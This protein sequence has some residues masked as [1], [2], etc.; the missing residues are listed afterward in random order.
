[1]TNNLSYYP[2]LFLRHFTEKCTDSI[3]LVIGGSAA[4]LHLEKLISKDIQIPLVDI[5][6]EIISSKS[7]EII[8]SFLV[9][10]AEEFCEKYGLT[11]TINKKSNHIDYINLYLD[12]VKQIPLNYFI[13]QHY[14]NEINKCDIINIDGLNVKTFDHIFIETENHICHLTDDIE[15]LKKNYNDSYKKELEAVTNKLERK[16]T[17]MKLF[18]SMTKKIENLSFSN[19]N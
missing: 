16:N 3:V 6:F 15:Y 9:S 1:M 10:C 12:G 11:C 17:I 19:L 13:N 14:L 2:F 8:F 7:N 18:S 4:Y 5:D